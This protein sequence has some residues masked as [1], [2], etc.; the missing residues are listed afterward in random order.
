MAIINSIKSKSGLIGY[1]EGTVKGTISC[2]KTYEDITPREKTL[3][4]LLESTL[5]DCQE[6]WEEVKDSKY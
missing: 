3:L 2:I 4:K 6:T 1:L 5:T